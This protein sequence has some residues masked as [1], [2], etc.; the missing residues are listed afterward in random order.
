MQW[1]SDTSA[2]EWLRDRLDDSMTASMHSV[3][4]H[5]FPAYARVLHPAIVRPVAG[6]AVPEQAATWADAASA[7]GTTLH[8]LAQWRSIVRTPIDA[9]WRTRIAPD[10]REFFAPIEGEL[11]AE[12]FAAIAT[13]LL[14]HT[15]TP[16]AGFAAL[17]E[18][19][20]GL[21][22]HLGHTPSRAFLT[23]SDDPN[24]Q[25]MLDRSVHDPFNNV[26]RKPTWQQGILPREISEGPRL[27]LPGR[28]H[29]LFRGELSVFGTPEWVLGVPWRDR[30]AEAHGF[31]PSAQSPSIL[32]P[33]DHAWVLVTEVDYDSTIVAGTTE[34]I[35][36][37]CADEHLEAFSIGE[38][39]DLT[40]NADEVNR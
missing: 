9:D 31:P 5:G 4:P 28:D 10:G 27:H 6:S 35:A 37:L 8:P 25:A 15:G 36:A 13:H 16:D 20:G 24:H 38:N 34:L 17:W 19:H 33:D 21:L 39:A 18:G 40:W 7:F 30:P 29:V 12:V 32:W 26:F 3:V 2:G 14:A 22:G 1:T 23:F 11:S